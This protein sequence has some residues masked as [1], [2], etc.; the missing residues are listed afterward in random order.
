MRRVK[1][2]RSHSG[3]SLD[4]FQICTSGYAQHVRRHAAQHSICAR[5]S[6]TDV[7]IKNFERF[8]IQERESSFRQKIIS[9][10]VKL[11][12]RLHS[13]LN[14]KLATTDGCTHTCTCT[15]TYPY[16]RL[17][18]DV[19]KDDEAVPYISFHSP[20]LSKHT[21]LLTCRQNLHPAPTCPPPTT[22]TA[23]P[24]K[25]PATTQIKRQ[26]MTPPSTLPP[27]PNEQPWII[28]QMAA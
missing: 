18:S 3:A 28:H 23:T 7:P 21:L 10:V 4:V 12:G 27:R 16:R 19:L 2:E 9:A 8:G 24:Q 1:C 14:V 22:A 26:K 20:T 13:H 15:C 6:N 17:G 25:T 11:P 5:R